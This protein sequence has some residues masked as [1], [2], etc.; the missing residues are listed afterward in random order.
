MKTNREIRAVFKQLS[1]WRCFRN[2]F[3]VVASGISGILL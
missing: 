2:G 3:V 1:L